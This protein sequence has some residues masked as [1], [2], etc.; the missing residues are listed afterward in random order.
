[1]KTKIHIL[2]TFGIIALLTSCNQTLPSSYDA[3]LVRADSLKY[4]NRQKGLE[5]L[6]S[7]DAARL[8]G[9]RN[10]AYYA[11]LL[12][13]AQCRNG[14]E[15]KNDSL[16]NVAVNYYSKSNEQELAVRSLIYASCIYRGLG[17]LDLSISTIQKAADRVDEVKDKRL[18]YMLYYQWGIILQEEKPFDKSIEY[19][20]KAKQY[21]EELNDTA[22]VIH[23][24]REIGYSYLYKSDYKTGQRYL[25][26][27]LQLANKIHNAI[28]I[29]PLN[30]F[31]AQ[32]ENTIGN[33]KA[34]LNYAN[35]A[36]KYILVLDEPDRLYCLKGNIFLNIN[37]LDS[38]EYYIHRGE[39]NNLIYA[40]AIT[41][42]QLSQ[43]CEKRG[44]LKEA[45]RHARNYA[46]LVDS[47]RELQTDKKVMRLQ[48]RY[49]Y[50][51][52]E[53]ERDR[54]EIASQRQQ[55]YILV[56][57]LAIV[58]AV[59][60]SYI[61]ISGIRRRYRERQLALE[62]IDH[63]TKRQLSD[64]TKELQQLEEKAAAQM[65]TNAAEKE[66]LHKEILGLRQQLIGHQE[67]V[68]K[69]EDWK[70]LSSAQKLRNKTPLSDGDSA[71]LVKAV[72]LCYPGFS[73]RLRQ[74]HPGLEN[75]D[76]VM[77]CLLKLGVTNS[78][79]SLLFNISD[80]TLRKRKHRLKKE[81]MGVDDKQ[82]KT[83]EDYLNSPLF[84]PKATE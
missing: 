13:E 42:K 16:I 78:D 26:E 81:K 20:S 68:K 65:Q 38:A 80:N 9:E 70:R 7:I 29:A 72:D 83:L 10:R 79:L 76:I 45:L 62:R 56:L 32:T 40:R 25:Q 30:L 22:F 1:M 18:L 2:I 69:I 8:K 12:S 24:L 50:S 46:E 27:S 71:E 28:L 39:N 19:F 52:I 73:D 55:I 53:A 44:N 60:V 51:K 15:I 36:Q 77:C 41:Q 74:R 82:F 84:T 47:I 64:K 61:M 57:A 48:Q 54:L 37:E 49:D 17:D 34:A 67:I 66:S 6:E 21:A 23:A 14:V 59:G 31:L 5:I 43:L 4:T 3:D 58:I 11:L 33:Y 63:D 75:A 35:N